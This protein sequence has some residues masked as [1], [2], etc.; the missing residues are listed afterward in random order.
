MQE[1]CWLPVA[2]P[3]SSRSVL[4]FLLLNAFITWNQIKSRT[5]GANPTRFLR[6]GPATESGGRYPGSASL[7]ERLLYPNKLLQVSMNLFQWTFCLIERARIK[8]RFCNWLISIDKMR[9][10]FPCINAWET[11]NPKWIKS[12][13]EKPLSFRVIVKYSNLCFLCQFF[14][15][16]FYLD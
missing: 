9:D 14:Q 1:I 13:P 15:A 11:R 12:G 8:W 16:K 4:E 10:C 7:P 6:L 2:N 3:K 5:N